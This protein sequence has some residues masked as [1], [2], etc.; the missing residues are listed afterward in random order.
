[1]FDNFLHK[2]DNLL[3]SQN[4]SKN[5]L[6][7]LFDEIHIRLEPSRIVVEETFQPR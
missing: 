7:N 4:D 1:M 5:F 6:L 3:L 2:N